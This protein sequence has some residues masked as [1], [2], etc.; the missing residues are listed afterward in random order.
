MNGGKKIY[1]LFLRKQGGKRFFYG[2]WFG[3]K[4]EVYC[5]RNQGRDRLQF[6]LHAPR[7]KEMLA[8]HADNGRDT[9]GDNGD[10]D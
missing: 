8:A 5:L 2:E 1:R 4:A 3:G 7:D 10:T 9:E 6:I